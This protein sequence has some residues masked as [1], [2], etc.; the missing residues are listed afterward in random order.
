MFDDLSGLGMMMESGMGS[1]IM[2]AG[3]SVASLGST[4]SLSSLI[5]DNNSQCQ[6]YPH[7]LQQQQF[8]QVT[9]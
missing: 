5:S 3:G 4:A 2:S 9:S 1:S 6:L 7:I 8:P